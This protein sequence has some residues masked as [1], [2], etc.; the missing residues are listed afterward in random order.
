[1]ANHL[2]SEER[3]ILYRIKRLKIRLFEKTGVVALNRNIH[4]PQ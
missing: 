2:T 1:M 4:P 3:E